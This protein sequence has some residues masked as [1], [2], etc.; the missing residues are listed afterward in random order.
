M[1]EAFEPVTVSSGDDFWSSIIDGRLAKIISFLGSSS[2]TC[3]LQRN[4]IIFEIYDGKISWPTPIPSL[5][6]VFEW[7]SLALT[8]AGL[9]VHRTGYS[10]LLICS[11]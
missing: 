9:E 5:N 11:T 1:S 4:I 8:S 7:T 2:K 10:P 3:L 6:I